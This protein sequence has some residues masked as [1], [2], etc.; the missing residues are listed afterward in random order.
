MPPVYFAGSAQVINSVPHIVLHVPTSHCNPVCI[1]RNQ[2]GQYCIA[3]LS[4]ATGGSLLTVITR[5]PCKPT[6]HTNAAAGVSPRQNTLS[7]VPWNCLLPVHQYLSV[8]PD[9]S[10]QHVYCREKRQ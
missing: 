8:C 2:P 7:H 5:F 1:D 6:F 9:S 4:P 10:R 3:D